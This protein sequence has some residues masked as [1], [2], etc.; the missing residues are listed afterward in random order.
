MQKTNDTNASL[1]SKWR[2]LLDHTETLV[3]STCYTHGLGLKIKCNNLLPNSK[4]DK[5]TIH[6]ERQSII[7]HMK[8]TRSENVMI[9]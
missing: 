1:I 6:F 8:M 3:K 2:L 5:Y 4:S 9:F 7:L